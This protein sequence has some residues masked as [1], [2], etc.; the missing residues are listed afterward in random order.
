MTCSGFILLLANE[1]ELFRIGG[2]PSARRLSDLSEKERKET[3]PAGEIF[4]GRY[5]ELRSFLQ[6]LSKC[7]DARAA[8]VTH[9]HG[10][11]DGEEMISPYRG[12]CEGS[13]IAAVESRHG[14][15]AAVKARCD[16]AEGVLVCLPRDLLEFL[17]DREALPLEK[18]M[19]VAAPSLHPRLEGRSMLMERSGARLGKKN[20][21]K[22]LR[23]LEC[24][25]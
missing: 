7:R 17:L 16:E 8:I 12:Y 22:V 25:G 20:A 15:A 5:S 10:L 1:S 18:C 24:D 9:A 11:V 3:H 4:G 21:S 23:A 6:R 14:I 2:P 13:E 19:V